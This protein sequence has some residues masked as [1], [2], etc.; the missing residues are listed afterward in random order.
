MQTIEKNSRLLCML[1]ERRG[2]DL[3]V[4]MAEAA[5]SGIEELARFAH[6]LRADLPAIKAGLTLGWSNRVTG[7]PGPSPQAREAPRRWPSEPD[8]VAAER[9]ASGLGTE[10]G[11]PTVTKTAALLARRATT[12]RGGSAS[13]KLR[14][15]RVPRPPHSRMYSVRPSR[16]LSIGW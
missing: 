8:A 5:H 7:G 11:L 3:G 4:W 16:A 10:D 1:R 12:Y 6:G 2:H 15:Q 13:R 14:A 9:P